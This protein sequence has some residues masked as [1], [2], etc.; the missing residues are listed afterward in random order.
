MNLRKFSSG[1]S[2]FLEKDSQNLDGLE[3]IL[4]N[5]GQLQ[6]EF[7]FC[8]YESKCKRLL[9]V[10]IRAHQLSLAPLRPRLSESSDIVCASYYSELKGHYPPASARC[11][12]E[13]THMLR[14][15][16]KNWPR[17]VR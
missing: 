14:L 13:T 7:R 9:C 10:P 1:N 3:R 6:E 15:S 8:I 11:P 12:C 17:S 16:H 2:F 4:S 5:V